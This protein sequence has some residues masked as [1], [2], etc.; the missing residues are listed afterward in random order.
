MNDLS[1]VVDGSGENFRQLV[2]ENSARG[3]VLVNYWTPSAGPCFMLWQVLERLSREYRGRFLL[4][5]INTDRERRLAR[6]NGITSV[7]TV[8]IY[9]HGKVVET[10]HG[11]QSERALRECIDRHVPPARDSVI[12][13][14]IRDY[15][16]GQVAEALGR[17]ARS[18][19]E[20]PQDVQLHA[21]ALK[22]L[23]REKRYADVET[24]CAALPDRVRREAAIDTLRVHARM[25]QLAR[26]AEREP[27][28]ETVDETEARMR[29]A[30]SAMVKDD[31]AG[32][33]EQLLEVV[34]QDRH[35]REELPRKAMLVIFSLLG[36]GHELT[37]RYQDAL[38]EV[39]HN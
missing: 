19:R 38:R 37:R 7:P 32:A 8:K 17:L 2:L 14:A 13:R 36:D 4:V 11:A 28:S 12:G 31:F 30:A 27:P 39:L 5:N 29:Q 24:W 20:R 3:A 16:S 34:R 26:E 35:Y 21:T 18:A 10:I 15:Q 9:R 33:L 6:E 25:L 1:H 22:L 23:L